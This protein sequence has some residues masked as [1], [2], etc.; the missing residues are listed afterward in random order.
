M[1]ATIYQILIWTLP[2]LLGILAFIGTLAVKA[3]VALAND[4]NEIKVTIATIL[5]RHDGLEKR[6][7]HID[8]RMAK[9]N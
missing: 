7:D 5:Q 4:V 2:V 1:D 3:L 6:V 9:W 8:E